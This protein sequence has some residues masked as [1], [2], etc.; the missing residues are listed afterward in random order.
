MLNKT[1]SQFARAGGESGGD[2]AERGL[3]WPE[4]R[5]L[6]R[7]AARRLREE[8]LPQ[9]AGSLTFT[10]TLALVPLLTIVLAIFT[11]FPAFGQVREMI[12][13]WFVQNLMPRAIASTISGNLTQFADKAKGLSAL[14]AVALLFTTAATMS[15]IERVF[16]QIWSVRQ[17]RPWAQRLLVY[18]ALLSLGPLLFGLSL[19]F[20]SQLVDVTGGLERDASL[21]GT[22]FFTLAS[23]AVTTAGYT[24]LYVVVPNRTV[25]WRDAFWG[26]LAAA[27]AF[28]VA[29]RGFG[30]FIRQF[31]TYAIIYGA[32][33]ALPLFLVWIYVTWMITLVGA[34]L[35]AALPVVKHE[36]WWYQ[37]APGGAFVDA[38]SVLKVLHGSAK[39]SGNALVASS[40][41]R[42]HTR[43]G[44]DELGRLLDR[45]VGEGWVG[46][47]QDEVPRRVGWRFNRHGSQEN[48][49][50]LADAGSLRLADV[51]RVFVFDCAA[52]GN[53][54]REEGE[55]TSAL[56]LDAGELARQVE[57]AVEAGLDQ[58]LAEHFGDPEE[59][60]IEK[61]VG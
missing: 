17:P 2:T 36:R 32:L 24:L 44:Y 6:V 5:D 38:M 4:A 27:I 14:G 34:V 9:V 52:A 54:Q 42:E 50:L 11:M 18:W 16:N 10:T 31:P 25:A 8:R 3:T 12:D 40:T 61:I 1:L 30:L 33:A 48:W 23:V 60:V 59:A 55:T 58:T 47:V 45:M 29:K 20:T 43:I 37:P 49:V 22:L 51:Y 56:A 26:A 53:V 28:E 39:L 21:L 13:A 19:S 57:D 41:I 15:L 35:T 7:F 46:R